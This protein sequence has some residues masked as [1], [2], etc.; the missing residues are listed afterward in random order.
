MLRVNGCEVLT[1]WDFEFSAS[2]VERLMHISDG[3]EIRS[4]GCH[5]M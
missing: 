2:G 5:M 3:V 1:F 4:C